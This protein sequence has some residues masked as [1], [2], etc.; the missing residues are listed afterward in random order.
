MVKPNNQDI[1]KRLEGLKYS[2]KV[3]ESTDQVYII[4]LFNNK[5]FPLFIRLFRK[6]SMMQF[7]TFFPAV[8]QKETLGDISRLLH[9]FNKELDIPGFGLDEQEK[10]IFFR[11]MA[12]V[13]D[14]EVNDHLFDAYVK[15][16][17]MAVETF[18]TTIEAVVGGKVKVEELIKNAKKQMK[19]NT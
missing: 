8:L 5:E 7:I 14:N 18:N 6:G 13:I 3:Q 1:V 15:A 11:I 12:T 2:P 19:K 16:S 17:K 10:L 4:L 9:L